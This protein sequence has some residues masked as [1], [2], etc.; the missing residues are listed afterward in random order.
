MAAP[1]PKPLAVK[2]LLAT[3][4]SRG[5]LSTAEA[6]VAALGKPA[7]TSNP[8]ASAATADIPAPVLAAAAATSAHWAPLVHHPLMQGRLEW[9]QSDSFQDFVCE[10]LPGTDESAV[11]HAVQL[12][13]AVAAMGQT[14]HAVDNELY[15]QHAAA[16]TA[17]CSTAGLA[18]FRG[19]GLLQLLLLSEPARRRFCAGLP[20]APG[21]FFL[22]AT[23]VLPLMIDRLQDT[24]AKVLEDMGNSVPAPVPLVVGMILAQAPAATAAGGA[25]GAGQQQR[26]TRQ[27]QQQ[28]AA[29][30]SIPRAPASGL[31]A[32]QQANK[33]V[34]QQQQPPKQKQKQPV[35]DEEEEQQEEEDSEEEDDEQQQP[36]QA[37]KHSVEAHVLDGVCYTA[38]HNHSTLVG[39]EAKAALAMVVTHLRPVVQEH[40]IQQSNR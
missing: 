3:A 11:A 19:L 12:C 39:A 8:G 5:M 2:A 25:G 37:G 4:V 29:K 34:Q 23:R 18:P 22:A 16:V 27:Q 1:P 15:S 38:R 36:G 40:Q 21:G 33:R 10:Q 7:N 30:P 26:P 20:N 35:D 6:L 31:A 24:V 13:V 32:S 17:A 14:V 28:A 9:W